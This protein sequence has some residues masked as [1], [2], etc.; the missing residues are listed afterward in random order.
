M[1]NADA[2]SKAHR[3]DVSRPVYAAEVEAIVVSPLDPDWH[4]D[5]GAES[6]AAAAAAE[7]FFSTAT[8]NL[9]P[10][11]SVPLVPPPRMSPPAGPAVQLPPPP[12]APEVQ[13]P[14]PPAAPVVAA[15]APTAPLAPVAP[16]APEVPEQPVAPV[17]ES[18]QPVSAAS[19]EGA[20]TRSALEEDS[21]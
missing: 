10:S 19:A 16:A 3:S 5:G 1:W 2:A 15:S 8:P 18:A 9:A 4:P 11:P 20:Y 12:A 14:P 6:G 17:T 7:P 21:E 13:L